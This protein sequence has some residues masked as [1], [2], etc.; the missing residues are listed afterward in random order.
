MSLYQPCMNYCV[1][2]ACRSLSLLFLQFF[3][4]IA[5]FSVSFV[6]KQEDKIA[7][8]SLLHSLFHHE[9]EETDVVVENLRGE[10]EIQRLWHTI[11][12]EAAVLSVFFKSLSHVLFSLSLSSLSLSLPCLAL[13]LSLSPPLSLLPLSSA[14]VLLSLRLSL[15]LS[16]SF[17]HTHTHTHTH[18]CLALSSRSLSLPSLSCCLSHLIRETERGDRERESCERERQRETERDRERQRDRQR[19]L[20]ADRDFVSTLT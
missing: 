9:M 16:L 12:L 11:S 3:L 4:I 17:T 2:S 7:E 1:P 5:L 19:D 10:T 14:L 18:P 15:S 8:C 13:S 20:E 6:W